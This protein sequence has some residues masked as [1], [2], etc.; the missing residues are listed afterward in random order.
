MHMID[1]LTIRVEVMHEEV[2]RDGEILRIDGNGEVKSSFRIPYQVS[3]SYD[4]KLSI[5]TSAL[6]PDG[7]GTEVF[8]SGNPVK[9]YQGHN[10]FGTDDVA[11][12]VVD[13]TLDVLDILGIAPSMSEIENIVAGESSLSRVDIAR[14]YEFENSDQVQEVIYKLSETA[15][16]RANLGILTHATLYMGKHSKRWTVKYYGKGPELDKHRI[17]MSLDGT[18]IRQ[19][20]D[21]KLRRELTLR[22]P[23]LDKLNL[24]KAG[25]WNSSKVENV[26]AEYVGRIDM[27]NNIE[28]STKKLQTMRPSL[29]TLYD[30]WRAGADLK[31]RYSKAQFYRYRK[32][33]LKYD[34]DI[35]NKQINPHENVSR[36]VK[37]IE[38]K[39]ASWPEGVEETQ[40]FYTPRKSPVSASHK[41]VVRLRAASKA[42]P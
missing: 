20:A 27:T 4:D 18:S 11:G 40:L 19:Y 3:G 2:I 32:E 25:H 29:R 36:L 6:G 39:A 31:T 28:L 15:T 23:E 1:W 26:Y 10:V 21:N 12:L 34:I 5:W 16:H 9:W 30:A 42:K 41:K 33:L 37:I 13:T 7:E 17:S 22:G 24:R 38:M 8:I 35:A 14:M